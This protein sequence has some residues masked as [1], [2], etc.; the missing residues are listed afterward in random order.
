MNEQGSAR[1]SRIV[2][3][4]KLQIIA[5]TFASKRAGAEHRIYHMGAE[6]LVAPAES[7]LMV[8]P[9]RSSDACL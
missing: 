7:A 4:G 2:A 1:Q 9:K 5:S 3:Q 6:T 8:Q